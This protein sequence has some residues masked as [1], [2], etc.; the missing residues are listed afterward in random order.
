MKRR[1]LLSLVCVAGLGALAACSES[2][3]PSTALSDALVTS[4]LVSSAGDAAAMDLE[5]FEA[6]QTAAGLPSVHGP[7]FDV[8]GSPPATLS[9]TRSRTFY[10]SAGNVQAAYD[11]LTTAS[12][13]FQLTISGTRTLDSLTAQVHRTRDETVSGLLGKETSRTWNGVG[14]SNDTITITGATITRHV[15]ESDLDSTI[16]VTFN[17]P[18]SSNPWPVSGKIVRYTD[19]TFT[20]T[21][22][23][24]GSRTISKRIE[25]DFPPDAQGNVTIIIGTVTC[26]LNL[27]THKVSNCTGA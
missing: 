20:A 6:N 25:I 27:V 5:Y 10:D 9:V 7:A 23:I 26:K 22:A 12:I 11:S 1:N 3:S 17:L 24:T 14:T 15:T 16:G 2:T 4:D 13:R 18:R 19:A 8:F 21:G